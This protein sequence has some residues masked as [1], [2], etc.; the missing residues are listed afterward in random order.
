MQLY[1]LS[2]GCGRVTYHA[3]RDD[4]HAEAKGI[5]W[6]PE[7][8]YIDLIDVDTDKLGILALLRGEARLK[9][10]R[11][12]TLTTRKGLKEIEAGD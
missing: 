10:L 7:E 6:R 12:W 11:T 3:T 9:V 1:R 4:A 8:V 2:P 5:N